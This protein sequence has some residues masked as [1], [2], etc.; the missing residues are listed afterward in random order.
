[1]RRNFSILIVICSTKQCIVSAWSFVPLVGLGCA[2]APKH[3]LTRCLCM[4]FEQLM[5]KVQRLRST[6]ASTRAYAQIIE[7]EAKLTHGP[8]PHRSC[9]NF[10]TGDLRLKPPLS[11]SVAIN[12][13]PKFINPCA[14]DPRP[15]PDFETPDPRKH[16]HP[17]KTNMD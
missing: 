11:P 10:T 8:R 6:S 7:R 12:F 16:Q 1:L 15:H 13:G 4:A 17:L 3:E 9:P 2:C 14:P 5:Y